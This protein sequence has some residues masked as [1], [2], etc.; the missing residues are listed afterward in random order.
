MEVK[1][2]VGGNVCGKES[3]DDDDDDDDDGGVCRRKGLGLCSSGGGLK[4]MFIAESKTKLLNNEKSTSDL[5]RISVKQRQLYQYAKE[6]EKK[7]QR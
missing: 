6:H 7:L 2:D 5:M 3:N 1:I 4:Q